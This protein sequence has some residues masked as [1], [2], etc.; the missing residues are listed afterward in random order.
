ME[1]E[2]KF[3]RAGGTTSIDILS[4]DILEEIFFRCIPEHGLR[5][6][7]L[8]TATSCWEDNPPFYFSQGRL[9][10]LTIQNGKVLIR[11]L[12]WTLKCPQLR[13]LRL[14]FVAED[15]KREWPLL[16]CPNLRF[17]TLDRPS[18]LAQVHLLRGLGHLASLRFEDRGLVNMA[19]LTEVFRETSSLRSF[20][21]SNITPFTSNH[22]ISLRQVQHFGVFTSSETFDHSNAPNLTSLSWKIVAKNEQNL[23][24]LLQM[25]PLLQNLTVDLYIKNGQLS[26]LV[27]TM[28]LLLNSAISLRS[29][30]VNVH[31]HWF[32]KSKKG[33]LVQT[34]VDIF[35]MLSEHSQ[36]RSSSPFGSLL[37]QM[38]ELY[39]PDP[40][41]VYLE[42]VTRNVD[43]LSFKGT[44]RLGYDVYYPPWDLPPS[45][46]SRSRH[47]RKLLEERGIHIQPLQDFD[48]KPL[49]N[50]DI[51]LRS[52]SDYKDHGIYDWNPV[53]TEEQ[54]WDL[55]L[56]ETCVEK[57]A[58]EDFSPPSD[59][60]EESWQT[61]D[62]DME[63]RERLNDFERQDP[64]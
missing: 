11:C 44:F 35:K 1:S 53:C 54:I 59:M 46:K 33:D 29:A 26:A 64:S 19:T 42:Q 28:H 55:D 13:Q 27:S 32:L 36:L 34:A 8:L 45:W 17:L 24:K 49:F 58:V 30:I 57:R 31:E 62:L 12:P 4:Q 51:E 63:I 41:L 52:R 15:T 6:G 10:S 21:A 61:A 9:E 3:L 56:Q 50:A 48:G 39:L 16:E 2:K 40:A 7:G 18:Q 25:F 5:F 38:H 43:L 23:E 20:H 14:A 22:S 47:A 60:G 37:L